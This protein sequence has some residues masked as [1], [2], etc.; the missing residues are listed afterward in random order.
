MFESLC[1]APESLGATDVTRDAWLDML[2]IDDAYLACDLDPHIAQ[3]HEGDA[4]TVES[5]H[6]QVAKDHRIPCNLW[7]P[8]GRGDGPFPCIVYLCG[9][10]PA[11]KWWYQPHPRWFAENGYVCLAIDAIQIGESRGVHHGTFYRDWWHWIS[12]GYSPAGVEVQCAR[13]GLDYLQTRREADASR[14]GLTGISGGATMSLYTAAADERFAAAAPHCIAGTIRQVVTDRTLDGHC[15][16]AMWVNRLHWDIPDVAKLIAPRPLL[17]CFSTGDQL[18]RP[19]PMR[20]MVDALRPLWP[21]GG[22]DTCEDDV[23]HAYSPAICRGI[24]TFFNHH[25]KGADDAGSDLAFTGP[26]SEDR[27]D[28]LPDAALAAYTMDDPP[29]DC[30]MGAIDRDFIEL[31]DA[32]KVDAVAWPR[33][34]ARRLAALRE[35]TFRDEPAATLIA[36]RDMGMN[37]EGARVRR[38]T[39]E[40]R[41]GLTLDA[42]LNGDGP[43]HLVGPCEADAHRVWATC[44]G[45]ETQQPHGVVDVRGT[46]NTSLGEGLH[47]FTRRAYAA[48]GYSLPERQT[49]DLTAGVRM[50]REHAGAQ[51]VALYGRGRDAAMAIYAALLGGAEEL[52]LDEPVATHWRGGPEFPNVLKVGDLADNLALFYPKPITFVGPRDAAFAIVEKVYAACGRADALRTIENLNDWK[53]T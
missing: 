7:L 8:R 26:W 27:G 20:D 40:T 15:D 46:G 30:R 29:Q 24:M 19:Q 12:Q 51:R 48:M 33:E 53:P 42:A 9:H 13:R 44:G 23:P 16:C 37:R 1:R 28:S 18:C 14:C 6:F 5:L 11:G 21:D 49:M 10:A 45:P 52:V 36:Q 47:W 38:I 43:V 39:F 35:W 4:F 2:G 22:I 17:M 31:P 32:M 41:D 34:Q 3:T 25:L 50:L